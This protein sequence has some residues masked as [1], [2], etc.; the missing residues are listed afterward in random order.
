MSIKSRMN[1][2]NEGEFSMKR[3]TKAALAGLAFVAGCEIGIAIQLMKMIHNFTIKE[4]AIDEVIPDDELE[5]AIDEA[6]PEDNGSCEETL[7]PE[8]NS[9]D[10]SEDKED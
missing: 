7:V 2:K 8:N 3:S 1:R 9:E 10:D 4:S 6:I 5:A